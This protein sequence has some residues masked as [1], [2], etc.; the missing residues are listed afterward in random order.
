MQF[1][2]QLR[3]V[4]DDTSEENVLK[5]ITLLHISSKMSFSLFSVTNETHLFRDLNA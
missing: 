2:L 4:S 5:L 1:H 3:T